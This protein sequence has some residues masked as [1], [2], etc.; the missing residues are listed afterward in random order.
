MALGLKLLLKK[1]PQLSVVAAIGDGA[2]EVASPVDGGD[3][4]EFGTD[5]CR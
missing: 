5:S 2:S 1:I 4:F 3:S